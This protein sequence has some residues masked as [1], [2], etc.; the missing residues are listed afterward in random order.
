MIEGQRE[1]ERER[2]RER[3]R[4]GTGDRAASMHVIDVPSKHTDPVLQIRDAG[5][6]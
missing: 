1:G 3:E 2:E 5:L 4:R 6:G